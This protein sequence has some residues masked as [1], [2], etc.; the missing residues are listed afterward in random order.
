[1]TR[2]ITP[3]AFPTYER[4]GAVPLAP[5]IRTSLRIALCRIPAMPRRG[6]VDG[7][8]VGNVT[9][10]TLVRLKTAGFAMQLQTVDVHVNG[11]VL[12][13]FGKRINHI[14]PLTA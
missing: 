6:E 9:I 7:D 5:A 11:M 13:F 3:T 1:M 4:Y 8:L 2:G 14:M 10:V 12:A